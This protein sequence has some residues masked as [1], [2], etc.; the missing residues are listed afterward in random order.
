MAGVY[1]K[2]KVLDLSWGIAGPMTAMLLGD[3]GAIV[4]KLQ[5]PGAHTHDGELSVCL[6]RLPFQTRL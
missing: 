5:P 2:R 1:D 6:K 4:T 3:N